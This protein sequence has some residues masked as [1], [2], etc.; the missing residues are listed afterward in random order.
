MGGQ[1]VAKPDRSHIYH[2]VTARIRSSSPTPGVMV[3]PANRIRTAIMFWGFAE[4]LVVV[5]LVHVVGLAWTML[6]GLLTSAIGFALLKRTG[7]ATLIKLRASFQG[8]LAGTRAGGGREVVDGALGVLGAL[9]LLLPGFL[10]DLV[11][12]AL[13]V[14]PVRDRVAAAIGGGRWTMMWT[15]VRADGR[16]AGGTPAGPSD[17]DLEPGEW[18]SGEAR[19]APKLPS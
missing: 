6:A 18:R 4:V 19:R 17:I 15:G 12:I 5:V 8:R 16:R 14:R 7:A 9:A 3:M 13:L 1:R 10:S 2:V 11:G